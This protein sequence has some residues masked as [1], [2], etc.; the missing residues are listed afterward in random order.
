MAIPGVEAELYDG[1]RGLPLMDPDD[2]GPDLHRAVADLRARIG[3]A[4]AVLVSTPEYAGSLPGPFKNLLDWVVGGGEGDR[5]PMA[6]IHVAPTGRGQ[7]ALDHLAI[8]LR[9]LNAD[10]V[11]DACRTIPI[12]RSQLGADGL[13]AAPEVRAA[14]VAA[15]QALVGQ[16]LPPA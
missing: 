13:V 5:K 4:D 14:L 11:D 7:G 10:V 2:D 15:V 1:M 8:V 9:Y 3:A 6:W 12:D 16:V